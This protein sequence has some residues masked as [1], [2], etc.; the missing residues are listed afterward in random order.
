MEDF[1]N[2]RESEILMTKWESEYG[3]KKWCDFSDNT[4]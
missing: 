2:L 3:C 1:Q 4:H